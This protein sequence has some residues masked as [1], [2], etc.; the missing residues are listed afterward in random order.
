MSEIINELDEISGR[1]KKIAEEF[2]QPE[3]TKTLTAIEDAA[4]QVGKAWS[5]S[6]LGY[7]SRVYYQNLETPPPG[8]HFSQEWGFKA[9]PRGL[10]GSSGDW[11]EFNYDDVRDAIY[12]AAGN[13]SLDSVESISQEA[14]VEFSDSRAEVISI[15]SSISEAPPDAF[16]TQLQ[17]KAEKLKIYSAQDFVEYR[18]PKG[19]IMT[20]DMIALGQSL[21]SPPHIMVEAQMLTY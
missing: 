15:L 8:A 12:E 18:A 17:E 1:L 7:H 14:T 13:L 4:Q 3:I 11:M 16:L 2:N 19:Q 5:G 9:L 6:W 20:R 10:G 21:Q